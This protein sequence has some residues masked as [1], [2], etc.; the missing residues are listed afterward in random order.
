MPEA[1]I[2]NISELFFGLIFAIV[3]SNS[4]VF[5]KLPEE[6]YPSIAFIT[7]FFM[8]LYNHAEKSHA[9]LL[10]NPASHFYHSSDVLQRLKGQI[11]AYEGLFQLD[12]STVTSA[13]TQQ[14]QIIFT[15]PMEC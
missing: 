9:R 5:F 3:F 11:C 1:F 10:K 14:C 15:M 12:T 8:D 4:W 13:E 2:K 7:L 6:E